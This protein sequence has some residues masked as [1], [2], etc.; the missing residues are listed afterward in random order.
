MLASFLIASA[1]AAR[2][3]DGLAFAVQRLENKA[4][5][6]IGERDARA[7]GLLRGAPR[8]DDPPRRDCSYGEAV[9]RVRFEPYTVRSWDMDA[10]QRHRGDL[11]ASSAAARRRYNATGGF[12]AAVGAALRRLDG[13]AL[14]GEARCGSSPAAALAALRRGGTIALVDDVEEARGEPLPAEVALATRYGFDVRTPASLGLKGSLLPGATFAAAM[15]AT[16][17]TYVLYLERHHS[18]APGASREGLV[19]ELAASALLLN[20]G[21]AFVRL[22]SSLDEAEAELRTR[23]REQEAEISQLKRE[24]AL[25]KSANANP[26]AAEAVK[27]LSAEAAAEREAARAAAEKADAQLRVAIADGDLATLRSEIEALEK[28]ASAEVLEQA[29]ARR[30]RLKEKA[31]KAK[32]K[33]AA[34]AQAAQLVADAFEED[35]EDQEVEAFARKLNVDLA[36]GRESPLAVD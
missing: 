6:D 26:L 4:L 20:R 2:D 24:I 1:S 25:Q 35:Q 16:A 29:R 3:D 9:T 28:V 12:R 19:D 11:F 8:D 22:R 32:K 17:A 30:E 10:L 5:L 14:T 31:K 27:S 34:H 15:R 21:A 36:A 33:G 23:E 18:V 13:A 7:A